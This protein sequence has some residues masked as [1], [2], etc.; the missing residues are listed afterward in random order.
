M[1]VPDSLLREKSSVPLRKLLVDGNDWFS[2]WSFPDSQRVF[3]GITQGVAVV[4][5]EIGC[6]LYTSPSPRDVP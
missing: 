1:V 2:T 3:P 5:L 4:G 6:L